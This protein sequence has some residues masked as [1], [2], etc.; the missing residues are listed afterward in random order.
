MPPYWSNNVMPCA[1]AYVARLAANAK[2]LRTASSRRQTMLHCY[3]KYSA[4]VVKSMCVWEALDVSGRGTAPAK[5]ALCVGV[6]LMSDDVGARL[7]GALGVVPLRD[8]LLVLSVT[9]SEVWAWT[10][11][12]NWMPFWIASSS[13]RVFVEAKILLPPAG[14]RVFNGADD[15]LPACM[16][17]FRTATGRYTHFS[18][19]VT[20]V[21]FTGM[22]CRKRTTKLL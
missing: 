11:T 12:R 14:R 2:G 10:A 3:N 6:S 22:C 7:N 5:P 17:G 4:H 13:E 19:L 18:I 1:S 8:R 16:S 20:S 15:G 21:I 9:N